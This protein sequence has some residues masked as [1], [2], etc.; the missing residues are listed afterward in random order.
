MSNEFF[1]MSN[2]IK[3][4]PFTSR[5][6]DAGVKKYTVYN[7]ILLPTVFK[8]LKNDYHHLTKHVQLWDVCCQKIIEIKG[9]QSPSLIQYLF[10]RDLSNIVTGK[11]YYS[12]I[13]NFEGG[14]L[15]DPVIFCLS[16]NHF[17][18]SL[19]DSDL[20]NWISA[21]NYTMN[22]KA[23]VFESD[24]ITIAIQGPKSQQLMNKIFG[25]DIDQ[26]KYFTFKNYFFNKDNLLVSKTGFSK[27]TGYEIIISNS[28]TGINLWDLIIKE[29]KD[30]NVRV[31]CPNMIERVENCLLS[32]GNEMTNKNIPQDCGLGN[33]CSLD[34]DFDFVGKSALL[35]KRDKGFNK[36]IYQVRFDLNIF[37]R[38][39]FI[40]NLTVF[41][42]GE[43]A[44]KLTSIVWSP[45]YK[46]YVGFLIADKSIEQNSK[47]YLINKEVPLDIIEI[48]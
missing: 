19:S 30:L 4:T 46:E 36:S 3:E 9:K 12:P 15:N 33:F 21:I 2:R 44:G 14:I 34:V 26:L 5:N 7:N 31:G 20:F 16:E 24:R 17:L 37:P 18:I 43:E 41:N 1:S 6:N 38:L 32:Y 28:E 22:F 35:R 29:G 11:A 45:R 27:Q 13:I 8:S 48:N 47:N 10:C 40:N 25:Q 39:S 42:K 23:E